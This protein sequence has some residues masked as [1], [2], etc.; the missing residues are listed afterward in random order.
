GGRT[1]PVPR[2]IRCGHGP[3][4]AERIGCIGV[5]ADLEVVVHLRMPKPVLRTV[6]ELVDAVLEHEVEPVVQRV[7]RRPVDVAIDVVLVQRPS[8]AEYA[9]SLLDGLTVVRHRQGR[10]Q[11]TRSWR[12][13]KW[14]RIR[15]GPWEEKR[16]V[17]PKEPHR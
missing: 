4:R 16:V 7:V 6:D 1:E 13:L 8:S 5:V 11:T 15:C 14:V 10:L 9:R 2:P 12:Y 17:L 3:V